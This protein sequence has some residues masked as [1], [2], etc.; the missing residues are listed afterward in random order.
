MYTDLITDAD[1]ANELLSALEQQLG[2]AGQRYDLVVIGGAAL[3][4]LDLVQ[5]HHSRHRHRRALTSG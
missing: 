1:V 4:T 3:L 2:V 5:T